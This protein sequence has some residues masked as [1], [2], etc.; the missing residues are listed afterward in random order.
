MVLDKRLNALSKLGNIILEKNNKESLKF[1][2]AINE[3]HIYNPWFTPEFCQQS[4]I[5]IA[6][7]WLNTQSLNNWVTNYPDYFF[8][9][10]EPKQIGVVMAG[11]IPFVGL[12]DLLSVLI[13]GHKF[14]GKVSS[15][16]AKLTQ[17]FVDLLINIEPRFD[18]NILITENKLEKFDAII[19]T[20]SDNTARYF[21]YYFGKYPNIIRKNRHSVAI[22]KGDETNDEL[23]RLASDI[24]SYFGLGCRNVSKLLVPKNYNFEALMQAMEPYKHLINQNKY[25][26]NHEY[27]RAIYLINHVEH[28]DNGFVLLKPDESLGS[29]VG[30]VY[31]QHYKDIPSAISYINNNND[32][33]QCVVT[34]IPKVKNKVS[35][36]ETQQ[37]KLNDYADGIDTIDFLSTL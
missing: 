33:L 31:Y 13:T 9:P 36:G 23:N 4:I 10:A 1:W 37:P 22:L 6:K 11:N 30:V 24:L 25:A 14:Y 27:H 18:D 32:T 16:D 8:K 15:K 2:D 21:E 17:A 26:N 34:N 12:H 20:G 5:A 28:L 3:A 19:A 7:E 35:F 29:P